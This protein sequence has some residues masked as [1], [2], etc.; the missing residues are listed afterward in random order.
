MSTGHPPS[1]TSSVAL[2]P[3]QGTAASSGHRRDPVQA[4][5]GAICQNDAPKAGRRGCP[6]GSPFLP[7]GSTTGVSPAR[8]RGAQPWGDSPCLGTPAA[9]RA[10]IVQPGKLRAGAGVGGT[11]VVA[12]RRRGQRE[13][14]R[15]QR[16]SGH[17][18]GG[19]GARGR[20]GGRSEVPTLRQ[21]SLA[22]CLTL[23]PQ[24]PPGAPGAVGT[25]TPSPRETPPT[26]AAP[27][28]EPPKNPPP[29]P[30]P[31]ASP[32]SRSGHLV[33][34][35]AEPRAPSG[36]AQGLGATTSPAPRSRQR[37]TWCRRRS[38]SRG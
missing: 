35:P 32:P 3:G 8:G 31:P 2:P 17:G 28:F 21:T 1:A 25:G 14:W 12:E 33:P 9:P 38:R 10:Q 19:V 24:I 16:R 30:G 37:L 13:R 27:N 29:S 15:G 20:R 34:R 4:S 36:V 5:A 26:A 18:G 6:G 11:R 23:L 22:R 7:G